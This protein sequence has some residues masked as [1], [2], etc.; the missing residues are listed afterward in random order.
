MGLRYPDE[1]YFDDLITL[2]EV[3]TRTVAQRYGSPG[4]WL[5]SSGQRRWGLRAPTRSQ[6]ST[7]GLVVER[8]SSVVSSLHLVQSTPDASSRVSYLSAA[9]REV[10][11]H[12]TCVLRRWS[13]CTCPCHGNTVA[14][15]WRVGDR[16]VATSFDGETT[17]RPGHLRWARDLAETIG[18]KP[19]RGT[20]VGR[21]EWV[22][23]SLEAHWRSDRHP[24]SRVRPRLHHH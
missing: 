20:P 8:R 3:S 9:C 5:D 15:V 2:S 1:I 21:E 12:A 18:L 10:A 6:P 7:G 17:I 22:Q 16:V 24:S 13:R 4:Q 11:G 23:A 14:L 19:V